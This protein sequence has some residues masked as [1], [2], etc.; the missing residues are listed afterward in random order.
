MLEADAC[1][2]W[3]PHAKMEPQMADALTLDPTPEGDADVWQARRTV[4][5]W[6]S[7][8]TNAALLLL[9]WVP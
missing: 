8:A 3:R 5:L 9:Q 6:I 7:L 4:A 1:L 2:P